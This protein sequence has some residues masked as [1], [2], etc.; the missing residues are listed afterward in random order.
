M[1]AQ[2]KTADPMVPEPHTGQEVQLQDY[3]AELTRL[4]AEVERLTDHSEY[5]AT[6]AA[7]PA[8]WR[9]Q[10]HGAN[11]ALKVIERILDCGFSGKFNP[12]FQAIVNRILALRTEGWNAAIEKAADLDIFSRD[13][14]RAL[15]KTEGDMG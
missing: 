12:E 14:V 13:R 11:V 2:R 8:W 1:T 6:C 10:E 15:T 3:R 5:D 7:H 9:G 4:R